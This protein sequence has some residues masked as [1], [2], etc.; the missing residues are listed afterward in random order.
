MAD[1]RARKRAKA[2]TINHCPDQTSTMTARLFPIFRPSAI[3]TTALLASLSMLGACSG[4]ER[5][6]PGL[7]QAPG[8]ASEAGRLARP[9]QFAHHAS[10]DSYELTLADGIATI[11]R[12][13][14]EPWGRLSQEIDRDAIPAFAGRSMAFSADIRAVLDDSQYGKPMEPSGLMVRI[15][16]KRQNAG[17]T[18]TAMTAAPRS[19]V[20]RLELA[21][22]ARIPQWQRHSV[23]FEVPDKVSRIEISAILSTGGT[24]QLRNPSLVAV[25]DRETSE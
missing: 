9:W 12:V 22:D 23:F 18:F 8:F 7:V 14:H 25:E 20:E 24:L 5:Y 2:A 11:E 17:S 10:A 4:D 21:A 19:R 3:R 16:H 6:D 13:G 15:W 1:R